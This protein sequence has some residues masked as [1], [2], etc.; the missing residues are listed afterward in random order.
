MKKYRLIYLTKK[1]DTLREEIYEA[2]HIRDARK[3]AAY[4]LA[5]TS[6][7]N[8]HRIMVRRLY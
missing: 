4:K 3:V 7:N 2:Y 6:H 1:N 5:T 8:L